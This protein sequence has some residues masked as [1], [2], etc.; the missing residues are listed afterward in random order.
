MT[1]ARRQPYWLEGLR[2]RVSKRYNEAPLAVRKP[3]HDPVLQLAPRHA[4]L[5][6]LRQ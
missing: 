5:Q 3:A 4:A 1:L 2:Y 6:F